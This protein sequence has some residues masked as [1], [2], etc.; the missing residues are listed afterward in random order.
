M[1]DYNEYYCTGMDCSG[2]LVKYERVDEMSGEIFGFILWAIVGL[3]MIGLG[4]SSFF[5]KKA[6]GF[7][8]NANTFPVKDVRG[9]NRATG[10]LFL[11]Y[12]LIFVVLGLP[13]LGGQN[14]ALIIVSILGVVIETIAIMV[15]YSLVVE[16]KYREK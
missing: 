4:I 1:G 6:V 9:Y 10:T 7:W 15:I 2:Y 13:L 11:V 8:A 12:G 3:F 16:K 14:N 5:S